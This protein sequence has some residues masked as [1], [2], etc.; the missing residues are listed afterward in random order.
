[1]QEKDIRDLFYEF[2]RNPEISNK[3]YETTE[4]IRQQLT[5]A[6]IEI[7]ETGLNTGLIARIKGEVPGKTIAL[8]ADIDALAIEEE[9]ELDYRSENAGVM[10]ACGHDIHICSVLETARRLNRKRQ[11]IKGEILF[12]FQPAEETAF[13]AKQVIDT[14]ILDRV[15]A[16]F[17]LHTNPAME[18]GE[19]GIKTGAITASV[20][21]IHLNI[22]GKGCHGAKPET[23]RDPIVAAAGLISSLQTVVSRNVS[24]TRSAVVSITHI[25]GGSSYNILPDQV[26][27]EGTIRTTDRETRALVQKRV[28]TLI[29]ANDLAYGVETELDWVE[30]PPATDNDETFAAAAEKVAKE[31]GLHVLLPEVSMVGEDFAFYQEKRRGLMVWIGVGGGYPLHSPRFCADPSAIDVAASFFEQL[32]V[33]V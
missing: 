21:I 14:G 33:Q 31:Q 28:R 5:A 15:D 6:G 4:R 8:R 17:S 7:L 30:G 10:H 18:V 1:M 16:I 24:P 9:T 19:I 25:E 20:D 3:E 23:G 11:Q 2:H 27:L 26:F 12:F 13:G 29:E 32:L 22:R